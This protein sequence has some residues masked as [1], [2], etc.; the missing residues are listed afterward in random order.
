MVKV[1]SLLMAIVCM[2]ASQPTTLDEKPSENVNLDA[3]SYDVDLCGRLIMEI[4]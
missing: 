2:G 1:V 4:Y 3:G